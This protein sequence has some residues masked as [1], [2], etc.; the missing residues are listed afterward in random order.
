MLRL[1]CPY[2]A[3]DKSFSRPPFDDTAA[4][5]NKSSLSFQITGGI[6]NNSKDKLNQERRFEITK[7]QDD[8]KDAVVSIK[9]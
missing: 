6:K 3:I 8:F 1:R 4:A 9:L 5:C 7:I 2:V